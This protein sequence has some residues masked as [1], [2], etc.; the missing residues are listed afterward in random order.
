MV[1]AQKPFLL[2]ERRSPRRLHLILTRNLSPRCTPTLQGVSQ[3]KPSLCQ[4]ALLQKP[5]LRTLSLNL[6]N[7]IY[8]EDGHGLNHDDYEP[9]LSALKKFND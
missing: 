8:E 3:T 4:V 5:N 2:S 1:S 6:L 9:V 7:R